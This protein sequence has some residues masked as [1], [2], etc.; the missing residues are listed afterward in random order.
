MESMVSIITELSNEEARGPSVSAFKQVAKER[1]YR[2]GF[3]DT[4]T[5]P[6]C[7]MGPVKINMPSWINQLSL[8]GRNKGEGEN[9]GR[10][11]LLKMA[12]RRH[13]RFPTSTVFW[14]SSDFS[15]SCCGEFYVSSATLL[16]TLHLKQVVTSA[17]CFG[18]CLK[19]Q[20]AAQ[21]LS[22]MVILK[23]GTAG[24]QFGYFFG[25][26]LGMVLLVFSP[27]L[28]IFPEGCLLL[29][30]H[31][32]AKVGRRQGSP[33][34]I[35]V[36]ITSCFPLGSQPQWLQKIFMSSAMF[37]SLIHGQNSHWAFSKW[38]LQCS[39]LWFHA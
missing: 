13:F 32:V 16:K 30:C 35:H 10:S 1:K 36:Y 20:W 31:L 34:W 6:T 27:G 24:G 19:P 21:P 25:K 23:G 9:I 5:W 7:E 26:L 17:V 15:C 39:S 29:S 37:T 2:W 12:C 8:L 28:L 33:Y 22:K 3:G 14:L 38:K 18:T 11:H 4:A